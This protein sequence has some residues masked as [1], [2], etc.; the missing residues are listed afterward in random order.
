MPRDF[1]LTSD[2]EA[3]F[4]ETV[5][6]LR[7]LAAN[8]AVAD[9]SNVDCEYDRTELAYQSLQVFWRIYQRYVS[10]VR[11]FIVGQTMYGQNEGLRLA[12]DDKIDW[13]RQDAE[14]YF[15][16]SMGRFHT[17]NHRNAWQPDP[18]AETVEDG[19]EAGENW[20]DERL[21]R[22]SFSRMFYTTVADLHWAHSFAAE[23]HKV[24]LGE[25][26]S[27]FEPQKSAHGDALALF[28]AKKLA[29]GHVL[30]RVGAGRTK[31]S[32]RLE[33]GDA[34]GVSEAS[35]KAWESDLRELV[36]V[37]FE[38]DG[39]EAAGIVSTLNQAEQKVWLEA[40]PYPT[41]RTEDIAGV[42]N[43]AQRTLAKCDLAEVRQ[44]IR[45]AREKNGDG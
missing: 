3:L 28:Q 27:L 38:L 33:V 9:P 21:E 39:F 32:A 7:R 36:E 25:R 43:L 13:N 35:L 14:D 20:F 15:F 4:L 30:F 42:L 10:W 19:I 17:F 29:V 18:I 45:K 24:N 40:V 41:F 44:R 1:E 26:S 11:D 6:L 37:S 22:I 12:L 34:I 31:L 2:E 16:E 8:F 5:P 23:L